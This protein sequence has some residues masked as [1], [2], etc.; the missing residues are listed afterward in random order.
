MLHLINEEEHPGESDG[1]PPRYIRPPGAI[2]DE[3][4]FLSTCT[5][6]NKCAEACPHGV[7]LNLTAV[8]GIAE[9]TPY[10]QPE[11]GPCRWCEDMPCV[12]AC[13]SGALHFVEDGPPPPIAKAVFNADKCL[14]EQ[15]V[16][17]DTCAHWCPVS[18]GAIRMIGRKVS[19]VEDK[20]TG[21]GLCA[22]HC[23]AHPPAFSIVLDTD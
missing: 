4:Q 23:E 6:C 18:A 5:R 15:G 13:E 12:D 19:F 20:C 16:L 21:C 3:I 22:Y 11:N 2:Q 9:G 14:N 8:A 7:I 17:C 10:L 1:Q